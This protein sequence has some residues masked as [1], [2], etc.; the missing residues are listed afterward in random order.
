MSD[1]TYLAALRMLAR[2]E[3]S[4]AQVRQRLARRQHDAAAIDDA[5][6]RLKDARS[7]DNA[8]GC[9]DRKCSA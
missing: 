3:L 2:R 9:R 1:E 8:S 6:S 4:E 5:I 7:I